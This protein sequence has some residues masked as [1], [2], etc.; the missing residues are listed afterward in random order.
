MKSFETGL[1][2]ADM[3]VF[4]AIQN[5]VDPIFFVIPKEREG[6]VY[7]DDWDNMGQRRTANRDTFVELYRLIRKLTEVKERRT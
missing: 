2:V 6:L 5:G 7:N 4:S 1:V 3:R